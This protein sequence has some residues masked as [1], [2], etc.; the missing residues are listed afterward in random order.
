MSLQE[1]L[2]NT[3]EEVKYQ[4]LLTIKPEFYPKATH[5]IDIEY[6][7]MAGQ[8]LGK[9]LDTHG[10]DKAIQEGLIAFTLATRCQW[11]DKKD[12]KFF[13]S[14]GIYRPER[15]SVTIGC[16]RERTEYNEDE[17]EYKIKLA[18]ILKDGLFPRDTLQCYFDGFK[19]SLIYGMLANTKEMILFLEFNAKKG[20]SYWEVK[21]GK[22]DYWETERTKDGERNR[23]KVVLNTKAKERGFLIKEYKNPKYFDPHY[24]QLK[25]FRKE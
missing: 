4:W 2:K 21:N 23:F 16:G 10:S 3:I 13:K 5:M 11:P 22:A 8:A 19:G 20:E 9:I 25:L 12:R 15:C 18:A 24:N 1:D 7:A 17:A 14:N 6:E